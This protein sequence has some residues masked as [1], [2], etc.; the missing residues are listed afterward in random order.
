MK[1]TSSEDGSCQSAARVEC[2]LGTVGSPAGDWQHR[3]LTG[4]DQ[5]TSTNQ[6]SGQAK[7]QPEA[8]PGIGHLGGTGDRLRSP[9]N[10]TLQMGL[11][12]RSIEANQVRHILEWLGRFIGTRQ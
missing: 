10:M 8:A 12:I 2:S 5:P 9:Q 1:T 6:G 7:E 3:A 11:R 4:S